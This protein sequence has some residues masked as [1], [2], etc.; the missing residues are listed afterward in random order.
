[1]PRLERLG[2]EFV[3]LKDE[4]VS[5]A[6]AAYSGFY[7]LMQ[8]IVEA[9]SISEQLNKHTVCASEFELLHLLTVYRSLRYRD[10]AVNTADSS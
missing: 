3:S 2:D 1:M 10:G 4:F 9:N 5:N 7:Q 8:M 6:G